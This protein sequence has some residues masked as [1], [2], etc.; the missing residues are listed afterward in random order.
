[1]HINLTLMNWKKSLPAINLKIINDFILYYLSREMS[2]K[3]I[4]LFDRQPT[5]YFSKPF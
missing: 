4:F 1:M 5:I 2:K 3:N